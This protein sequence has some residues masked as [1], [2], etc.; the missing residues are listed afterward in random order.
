MEKIYFCEA[1]RKIFDEYNQC[2]CNGE[3][4]IKPMKVGTPVNII[5]TKLKG[6]VYRMRDRELDILITSSKNKGI[7]T[8]GIDQVRKIL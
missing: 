6:K 1:C 8:Y 2:Q 5:G 4:S 3:K 7:Q